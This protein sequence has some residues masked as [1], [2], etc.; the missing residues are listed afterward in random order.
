MS[1][2]SQCTCSAC[3]NDE[4]LRAIHTADIANERETEALVHRL[5]AELAEA[6]RPMWH[7]GDGCGGYVRQLIEQAFDEAGLRR[8]RPAPSKDKRKPIPYNL[9]ALVFARDDLRCVRCGSDVYLTIDHIIPLARGG[10]DDIE[11]LQTLCRPCNAAKGV[12]V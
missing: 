12:R 7:I 2:V 3:A 9:R 5:T 4:R 10:T 1:H 6:A 8:D 11:N